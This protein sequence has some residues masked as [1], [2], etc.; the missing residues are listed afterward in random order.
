M[1]DY[2]SILGIPQN[3]T[4][5]D[6]KR[7][8]RKMA[9][10]WHPDKNPNNLEEANKKFK[11]ISE[12]YEVLSDEKKRRIYDKY[13]KDGIS[14]TPSGHRRRSRSSN[15]F[16]FMFTFRDPEE[17]FKEFFRSSPFQDLFSEI[18]TTSSHNRDHHRSRSS[19]D[20]SGGSR[21]FNPF[22]F[23]FGMD[24]D[25]MLNTSD[26]SCNGGGFVSFT[27]FSK[28]GAGPSGSSVKRTSTTTKY[29]N[30]KKITTKKVF[31]NG[32]ETTMTYE[33]DVLVSKTVDG[34]PQSIT[35]D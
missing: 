16:D 7:A 1:A 17:V 8:Y 4:D 34:V 27:N 9:L 6:V 23:G 26:G 2:Y 28:S 20:F 29:I 14:S 5:A 10:K 21:L 15:D 18:A 11:E 22:S 35:Y 25:D 31:A 32:K 13:G 3:A 12:A 19:R 24:M 30:G 33:N